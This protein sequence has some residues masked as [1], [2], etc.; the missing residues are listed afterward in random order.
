MKISFPIYGTLIIACF[1]STFQMGQF[2]YATKAFDM[3]ERLDPC[4]EYSGGKIGAS[5]GVFQLVIAGQEPRE[6]LTE[7]VHILQRT[8]QPQ[9]EQVV[10]AIGKWAR[11][12]RIGSP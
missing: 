6:S 11:E 5:V 1:P 4:P 8:Q 10:R 7:V 9:A 2:L 12:S 3:L